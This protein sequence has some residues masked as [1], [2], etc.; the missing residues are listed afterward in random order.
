MCSAD[1][2]CPCD[3]RAA[4]ESGHSQQEPYLLSLH[5]PEAVGQ[6]VK[7]Q[8]TDRDQITTTGGT[9]AGIQEE[10][11]TPQPSGAETRDKNSR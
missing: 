2:N 1:A 7:A 5:F 3:P 9:A 6:H 4:C 11:D 10:E 8:Q